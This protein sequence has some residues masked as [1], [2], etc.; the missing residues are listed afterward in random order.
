[1]HKL[2]IPFR[3]FSTQRRNSNHSSKLQIGD[4]RIRPHYLSRRQAYCSFEQ[5]ALSL[6]YAPSAIIDIMKNLVM[7]LLPIK[8]TATKWDIPNRLINEINRFLLLPFDLRNAT[9]LLGIHY[10]IGLNNFPLLSLTELT[11]QRRHNILC[12]IISWLTVINI[13]LTGSHSCWYLDMGL[14]FMLFYYKVVLRSNFL[15]TK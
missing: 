14:T 15:W 2:E 11:S 12:R 10:L 4:S 9:F 6:S 8:H 13:Q 7:Q 5:P 3:Y 1:M